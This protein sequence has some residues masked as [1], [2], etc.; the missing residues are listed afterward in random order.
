M[1]NLCTTYRSTLILKKQEMQCSVVSCG[2]CNE[3]WR[4][5]QV[6]YNRTVT[7]IYQR[8][9]TVPWAQKRITPKG[10][11]FSCGFYYAEAD[12]SSSCFRLAVYVSAPERGT[13]ERDGTLKGGGRGHIHM[14]DSAVQ[15]YLDVTDSFTVNIRF[16]GLPRDRE[17][18]RKIGHS[19]KSKCMR[20]THRFR[21]ISRMER[22]KDGV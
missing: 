9:W 8:N 1:S 21:G 18:F 20:K 7:H 2:F 6:D 15:L 13:G 19:R 22:V 5:G 16:F 14:R 4:T 10:Q 11:C 12:G 17:N 3:R